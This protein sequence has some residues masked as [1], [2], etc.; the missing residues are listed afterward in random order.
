MEYGLLTLLPIVV[1]V[2][3]ALL[4]KRTLEPLI[5]GSFTAYIIINGLHFPSAWA[6]AFFNVASNRE[7]Q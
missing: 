6:D 2:A 7:Y 3:L 4:T 5:A 1:V